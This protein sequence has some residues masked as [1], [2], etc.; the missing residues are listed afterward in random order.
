MKPCEEGINEL[1]EPAASVAI[2]GL[3][4][5]LIKARGLDLVL[6]RISQGGGRP[7][8][9]LY[10]GCPGRDTEIASPGGSEVGGQSD[11]V[12][13][14]GGIT[15]HDCQAVSREVSAVLDVE[16][17]ISHA[18]TLEVSSPGLNRPLVR[19]RDFRRFAGRN[20][21]IR[22]A[23]ALDGRR[24]FKGRLEGLEGADVLLGMEQGLCRIPYE[25][26]RRARIEYE[27]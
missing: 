26:I 8:L 2:R 11:N 12:P 18:Y 5:P 13:S 17:P 27:F 21:R 10:L 25:I 20:V 6:V 9:C 16:D 19:P 1:I 23:R 14:E 7:V 15:L 4:E 22:T 24:S 3:V